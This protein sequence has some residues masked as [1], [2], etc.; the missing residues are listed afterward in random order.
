MNTQSVL[1]DDE[2]VSPVIGVILLISITVILAT[3]IGSLVLGLAP[4]QNAP[5]SVTFAFDGNASE[6]TV[7]HDGGDPVDADAVVFRGEAI[8]NPT[9]ATWS[10]LSSETRV[11]T[12]DSVTLE[13]TPSAGGLQQGDLRVIWQPE[14]ESAGATLGTH[15]VPASS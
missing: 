4:S 11:E 13:D 6:L 14:D 3:I 1:T 9:T 8:G 7:S 2:A 10:S 15:P 12:G 5:P